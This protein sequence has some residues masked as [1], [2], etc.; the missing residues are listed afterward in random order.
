M[1][2]TECSVNDS[3][4]EPLFNGYNIT[5]NNTSGYSITMQQSVDVKEIEH[6]RVMRKSYDTKHWKTIRL[7]QVVR[8]EDEFGYYYA[9]KTGLIPKFESGRIGFSNE[10][11]DEFAMAWLESG[12]K[13][14]GGNSL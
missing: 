10:P 7:G 5:F 1:S 12:W 2:M 3:L 11:I 4:F 6:I 8:I 14:F 13:K 9:T